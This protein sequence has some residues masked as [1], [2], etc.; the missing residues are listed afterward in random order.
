MATNAVSESAAKDKI[1]SPTH[2][3][4]SKDSSSQTSSDSLELSRREADQ[5]KTKFIVRKIPLFIKEKD[6]KQNKLKE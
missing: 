5:Q 6:I 2:S 4:K 3:I 1:S